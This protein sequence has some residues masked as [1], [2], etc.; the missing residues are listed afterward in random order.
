VAE[1]KGGDRILIASLE[2]AV[3]AHEQYKFGQKQRRTIGATSDGFP[4]ALIHWNCHFF[5]SSFIL[6]YF[7]FIYK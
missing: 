1:S 4:V 7:Y 6:F 5:S 2:I 3:S